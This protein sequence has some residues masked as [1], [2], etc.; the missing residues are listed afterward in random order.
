[1]NYEDS[2]VPLDSSMEEKEDTVPGPISEGTFIV[3]LIFNFTAFSLE[4]NYSSCVDNEQ[5]SILI[6]KWMLENISCDTS[7]LYLV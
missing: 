7:L 3:Y 5:V 6:T 1:M 4:I 2:D